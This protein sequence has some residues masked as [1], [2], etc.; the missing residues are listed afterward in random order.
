MERKRTYKI[1]EVQ[2]KLT[3]FL[4]VSK[5]QK[6]YV[7]FDGDN[8]CPLSDRYRVFF[9]LGRT[10]VHCG[11]EGMFFA[12]ERHIPK[13]ASKGWNGRYHLNLY[14]LDEDGQEVL[15]TKD[16]VIPKSQG[17]KNHISNYQPM[18]TRCNEAKGCQ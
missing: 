7:S 6:I 15:M 18:C 13:N 14:A 3:P 5:K 12:L 8:V 4:E 10:C 16:H 11:I 2:E 1:S 17:G 9:L